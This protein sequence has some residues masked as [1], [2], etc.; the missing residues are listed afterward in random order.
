MLGPWP[1]MGV[2]EVTMVCGEV[3]RGEVRNQGGAVLGAGQTA[4]RAKV[5]AVERLLTVLRG[6]DRAPLWRKLPAL[7]RGADDGKTPAGM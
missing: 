1:L 6:L 4:P 3:G 7:K 5:C 2:A